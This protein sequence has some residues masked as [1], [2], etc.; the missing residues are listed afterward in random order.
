[1]YTSYFQSPPHFYFV[2]PAFCLSYMGLE[3]ALE[4][5]REWSQVDPTTLLVDPTQVEEGYRL[6]S[7]TGD[8]AL[9]WRPCIVPV[10]GMPT[11][12]WI[13]LGTEGYVFSRFD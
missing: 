1:M 5:Y 7:Q 3:L 6:L 13:V 12:N 8:L 10:P 9:K 11:L 4:V 2:N